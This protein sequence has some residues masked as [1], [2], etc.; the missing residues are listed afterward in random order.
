MKS[1]QRGW[2]LIEG[3]S[4]FVLVLI[5]GGVGG[6]I[7]NIVKLVGMDFGA[8]TGMLIVRAIGIVVPPL[9]AVMGFL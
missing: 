5:L 7:A 8:I 1:L 2:T 6:W 9:G 4:V 3:A